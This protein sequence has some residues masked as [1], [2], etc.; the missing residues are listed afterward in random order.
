VEGGNINRSIRD[1]LK[2]VERRLKTLNEHIRQAT[3]YM[4]HKAVYRQYQ[5]LKPRKQAMFAEKHH[6]EIS[7]FESAERHLKGAM[8]SKTT[9][10]P[11]PT[12]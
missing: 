4:Q 6:G 7:L 5:E 9:L 8:N 10:P 2:P 3:M 11:F 1:K 12:E